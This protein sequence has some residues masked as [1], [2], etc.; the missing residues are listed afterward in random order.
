MNPPRYHV[1]L[2]VAYLLDSV[3]V[4]RGDKV[5]LPLSNMNI[6]LFAF[7][8][9]I[10]HTFVIFKYCDICFLNTVCHERQLCIQTFPPDTG[11]VRQ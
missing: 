6:H 5:T 8:L 2:T 3:K 4:T 10:F 7:C 1:F 9:Y 11:I